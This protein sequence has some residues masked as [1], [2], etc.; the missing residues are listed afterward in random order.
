MKHV[1]SYCLIVYSYFNYQIFCL[2]LSFDTFG[3][4]FISGP[5]DEFDQS[6]RKDKAKCIFRTIGC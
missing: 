4:L 2:R 1:N 6:M 5:M 3:R